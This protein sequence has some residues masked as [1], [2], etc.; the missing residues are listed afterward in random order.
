[1]HALIIEDHGMIALHLEAL[2]RDLG[3]ASFAF[4]ATEEEAVAAARERC[5]DL[6]T[7]DVKLRE[8]NG[9]SAVRRIGHICLPRRMAIVYVTANG[10]LLAGVSSAVIVAKPFT[11]DVL[12]RAVAAAQ[13]A[14]G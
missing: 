13:T 6:I 1:V 10:D 2:L 9:P 14:L 3:F 4:A 7:A 8:G 12:E 5:P 11:R